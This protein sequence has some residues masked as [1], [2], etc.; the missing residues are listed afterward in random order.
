MAPPQHACAVVDGAAWCWGAAE[1]GRLGYARG[2]ALREPSPV[3]VTGLDRGVVAIS[4]GSYHGCAALVSGRVTCWGRNDVGQLGAGVIGTSPRTS[5][6]WV[7][8]F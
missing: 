3:P 4:C 2:T 1:F 7:I 5:P 6:S 8:G